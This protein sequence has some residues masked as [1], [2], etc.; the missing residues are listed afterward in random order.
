MEQFGYSQDDLLDINH[1]NLYQ[2]DSTAD[3]RTVLCDVP[4]NEYG[5]IVSTFNDALDAMLDEVYSL[6]EE[7]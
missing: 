2:F 4:H 6:R 5:F 7:E 3:N 1:A